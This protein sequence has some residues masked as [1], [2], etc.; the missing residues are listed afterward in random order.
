MSISKLIEIENNRSQITNHYTNHFY[1]Y[2]HEENEIEILAEVSMKNTLTNKVEYCV[3]DI[4]CVEETPYYNTTI[5]VVKNKYISYFSDILQR[6][7]SV[8]VYDNQFIPVE[9]YD[10][11]IVCDKQ[12]LSYEYLDHKFARVIYTKFVRKLPIKAVVYWTIKKTSS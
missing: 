11:I 1:I 12:T 6:F 4:H 2:R 7:G 3:N 8:I 10:F 5:V 9:D